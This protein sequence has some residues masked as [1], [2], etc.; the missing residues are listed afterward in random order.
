MYIA[1]RQTARTRRL[2]AFLGAFAL[3]IL[4]TLPASAQTFSVLYSFIG[5]IDGA[6]PQAGLTAD[7]AGNLY[8]TTISGG[9][10]GSPQCRVGGGCGAVFK[11]VHRGSGWTLVPI[12]GFRGGIDA[13]D[14]SRALSS[15]P[16]AISTARA[17][18]GV[19][20]GATLAV[21]AQFIGCRLR[22]I[23]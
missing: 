3:A 16:T 10:E 21:A 20:E 18:S 13:G 2:A 12:Y 9:F 19:S 8:G 6:V 11:L 15:G 7:E 4:L 17:T 1:G 5:G 22:H 14:L 23:A